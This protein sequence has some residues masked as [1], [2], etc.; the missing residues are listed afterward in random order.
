[1][2]FGNGSLKVFLIDVIF[3]TMALLF[4]LLRFYAR[5]AILRAFGIDDWIMVVA[6][7]RGYV[8]SYANMQ[9]LHEHQLTGSIGV[10][11][12]CHGHGVPQRP[13]WKRAASRPSRQ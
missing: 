9:E 13:L 5:A 11:D 12:Y 7:V 8:A 2:S 4:V 1:M 6:T 10:Y 3:P